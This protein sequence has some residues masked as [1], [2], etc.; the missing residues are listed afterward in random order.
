VRPARSASPPKPARCHRAGRDG[1]LRR[2]R[3]V[4]TPITRYWVDDH[5]IDFDRA[6]GVWSRVALNHKAARANATH[7]VATAAGGKRAR[8][9]HVL[10]VI[11]RPATG[12]RNC[13]FACE[14]VVQGPRR[15]LSGSAMLFAPTAGIVFQQIGE[16]GTGDERTARQSRDFAGVESWSPDFWQH[17]ARAPTQAPPA[18][19]GGFFG[20]GWTIGGAGGSR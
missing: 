12:S 13:V 9:S 8:L 6:M 17:S 16:V 14:P 15:G 11:G 19:G 5:R 3:R 1:W 7:K 2:P 10:P 18:R 4:R 20:A